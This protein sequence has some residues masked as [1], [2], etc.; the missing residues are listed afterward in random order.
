MISPV[1]RTADHVPFDASVDTGAILTSIVCLAHA[2]P[3]WQFPL[4]PF[5]PAVAIPARL[6]PHTEAMSLFWP[7]SPLSQPVHLVYMQPPIRATEHGCTMEAA[8][9]VCLA[10]K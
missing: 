1:P 5:P 4:W 2:A 7:P 6:P 8:H 10:P 3:P 9:G